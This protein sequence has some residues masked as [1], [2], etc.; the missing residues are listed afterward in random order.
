MK[1]LLL[2]CNGQLGADILK[3]H[4]EDSQGIE[5]VSLRRGDLDV[6]NLASIPEALGKH[7]FNAVINCTSY[8]K[9]DEVEANAQLATTVN[10]HAVRAIAEVC[11]AKN[12]RLLHISTDYVFDG[13]ATRPYRETDAPAPLNVYGSSKL[14][15]EALA[16]VTHDDVVIFRVASLF[17]IAGAS[18][19]GGNF[20][21]TM[22]RVGKEKGALRVVADQVMSPTSTADV[23]KRIL[24]S[25]ARRIPAGIYHAV[26]SGTASWYEFACRIIERSGVKATVSPIPASAYPL[27]AK[28]PAFSALDNSRLTTL[29]GPIPNWTD[30]LD[31]YLTAKGH[32]AVMAAAV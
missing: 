3:A 22:I 31:R 15:G 4:A 5:L 26:N 10:A 17:G 32:R 8:H 7:T 30:A 6:S 14:Q 18:G 9:T 19:K 29:L 2:G 11:K 24:A 20:V 23:A 1:V 28:R 16:R 12:A 21:E 27:P 25:L 13:T